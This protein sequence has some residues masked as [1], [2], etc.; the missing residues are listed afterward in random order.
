[1][2]SI[3][4]VM[5]WVEWENDKG[6]TYPGLRNKMPTWN[7]VNLSYHKWKYELTVTI[8]ES[9]TVSEWQSACWKKKKERKLH[10][11]SSFTS[12]E[13]ILFELNAAFL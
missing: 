5:C 11:F 7:P 9:L 2:K 3:E 6:Q 4:S 1:M 13:I 12:Y 10:S 8:Y